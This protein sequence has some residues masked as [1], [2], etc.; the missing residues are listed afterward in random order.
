M[1]LS[2]WIGTCIWQA[3]LLMFLRSS[4]NGRFLSYEQPGRSCKRFETRKARL[5]TQGLSLRK[6][7]PA[8]PASS[9]VTHRVMVSNRGRDTGLELKLRRALRRVG[10]KRYR[11]NHR[12]GRTR[13][14]I[15]F[16][17]KKVAVLVHGCFWHHCPRCHLPLPKM[18]RQFW[19]RKFALNRARDERVRLSLQA[20]RMDCTRA[21]GARD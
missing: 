9:P 15:A 8:P 13:V 1:Q 19:A 21:L 20:A 6:L 4:P 5:A 12:V 17:S 11:V 16:P 7:G 14:D 10:I 3:G 18:H 2:W